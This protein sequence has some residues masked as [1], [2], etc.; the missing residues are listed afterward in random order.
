MWNNPVEKSQITLHIP[1]FLG[2]DFEKN[3]KVSRGNRRVAKHICEI[4]LL[5]ALVLIVKWQ[6]DQNFAL[7]ICLFS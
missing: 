3:N 1:L 7:C 2:G 6:H 5:G 4:I